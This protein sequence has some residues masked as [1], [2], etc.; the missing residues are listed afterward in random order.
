MAKVVS[1]D[2]IDIIPYGCLI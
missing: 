2:L 1:M